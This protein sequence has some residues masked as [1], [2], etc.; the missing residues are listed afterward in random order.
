MKTIILGVLLLPLGVL[1]FIFN[2]YDFVTSGKIIHVGN[3]KIARE[4]DHLLE[5]SPWLSIAVSLAR[6]FTMAIG[7]LNRK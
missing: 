2:Q 6:V 5:W 1:L 4:N 3:L 7:I